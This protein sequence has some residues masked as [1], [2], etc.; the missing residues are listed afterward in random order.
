MVHVLFQARACAA[1]AAGPWFGIIMRP[2]PGAAAFSSTLE[3]RLAAALAESSGARPRPRHLDPDGSPLYTNRLALESSPYLIQHAHN[4]VNWNPWGDEAFDEARRLARPVFLSIGY[5]TCHWC[6]VM[7][8]ESF[9]DEPIAA[10]MNAHYVCIKVDREERPDVDAVYMSATQQ[11]T[12][13][14]GWPMSLWLTPD[15]EPFFAGTYFPP[16]AGRRGAGAGFIDI[17]TELVRLYDADS[18]RVQKAAQALTAAVRE[19]MEAGAHH[20]QTTSARLDAALVAAAVEQCHRGFDSENGGLRLPQK[21]PSN[22]PIRLLLRHHQRTGDAQ[23][24]HMA[25][26][27]LARMAEGGIYDQVAGGFHRY[28]T[29]ARWLVPHF[30][31]MLYDNALL[32][33]AY[34]EAWLVT[35]RPDFARVVRETCDE[36]LKTFAAPEG[37]FYSATDAD[38]EGEEGKFFVWSEDQIRA[39]LGTGADTDLFLRH[40]GVTAGRNFE[41][42]NILYQP[43][44]DEAVTVK[45]APAR[46]KLAEARRQRV[47]PLRDDKILA[48]W[49]GLAISAFAVAGRML[50]EQRYVDRAVAAADF[51][52]TQMRDAQSGRLARS[53]RAGHLGAPGFLDDYAFVAAGM[54]DLFETTYDLRWFDEACRLCDETEALF[55]DKVRGGWFM[56]SEAHERLLARERPVFDGAEPAGGSVALMNAARLAAF[57]DDVRWQQVVDRA[58]GFYLPIIEDRPMALTEAL[59]AVDFLAGPVREIVLVLPAGG[60]P[61]HAFQA[62]LREAFCPRKVLVAG[63]ATSPQWRDLEMRIPWLREKAAQNSLATAYVC[64]RGNCQLPTTDPLEFQRQIVS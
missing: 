53:Y 30:E 54:L 59:L 39:V 25:V 20:A 48:A 19:A 2:L 9:E 6:H 47:P 27:T 57:T 58:L 55:A 17:L 40:Y 24:L 63:D 31:K 35:K 60:D 62:I 8:E 44:P 3:S 12:G 23:A 45:L 42:G 28:A 22:L 1:G 49:N 43:Q 18:D 64:W 21:F 4:P 41:L 38:S 37:G 46:T 11:L 5:A 61:E 16:Y 13:S 36:L 50:G 52:A 29:D 33:V 34:A 56:A 7:E 10:F 14:G 15:R 32:I 26:L 51:L